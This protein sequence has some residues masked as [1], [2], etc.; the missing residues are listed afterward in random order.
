MLSDCKEWA[1]EQM[2][3]LQEK[4]IDELDGDADS[5]DVR[6]K[7]KIRSRLQWLGSIFIARSKQLRNKLFEGIHFACVT[8]EENYSMV[9][10]NGKKKYTCQCSD[11]CNTIPAPEDAIYVN[12][13]LF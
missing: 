11:C 13:L 1:F 8:D 6:F 10:W 9:M 2:E 12:G 3:E 5:K 7:M 4:H